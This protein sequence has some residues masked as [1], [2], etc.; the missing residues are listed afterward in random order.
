MGSHMKSLAS[1]AI[2]AAACLCATSANAASIITDTGGVRLDANDSPFEFTIDYSAD[3]E[4]RLDAVAFFTFT[5][6]ASNNQI[7]NFDFRIRNQSDIGSRL[8][9]FGFD[10]NRQVTGG[11][12]QG[13]GEFDVIVLNPNTDVPD[14]GTVDICFKDAGPAGNCNNGQTGG[15]GGIGR[16]MGATGS[17]GIVLNGSQNSLLLQ[18]FFVR[19]QGVGPDDQN[20]TGVGTPRMTSAVPEP[21]TWAMMLGGFG[22][23]GG[24]MRSARKRAT[25]SYK[26]A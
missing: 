11:T 26:L 17:F 10:T 2:I 25:V 24:A 3:G 22:M 16:D 19:F 9:V 13:G 21:A 23:V 8:S 1:A 20:F 5:R 14:I 15:V 7:Y 6:T 4:E 18:D 12:Y